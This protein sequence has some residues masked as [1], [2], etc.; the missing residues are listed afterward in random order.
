MLTKLL[1]PASTA[2]AKP[3][4]EEIGTEEENE[5]EQ[6]EQYEEDDD[7]EDGDRW[8]IEQQVRDDVDDLKITDSKYGFALTKSN[9]FSKLSVTKILFL[10][11]SMV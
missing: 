7:E 6:E 1:T 5:N 2:K 11:Y 3:L 4:I 8:F 10:F 9:I